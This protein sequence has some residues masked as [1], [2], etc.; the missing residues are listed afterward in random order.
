MFVEEVE[1]AVRGS[2]RGH[3]M[4]KSFSVSHLE[5]PVSSFQTPVLDGGST[6]E[7]IL[8]IYGGRTADGHVSGGDAKTQA[9]R[10]YSAGITNKTFESVCRPNMLLQ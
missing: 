5:Q 9:L 2:H 10:T 6:G 8:H 3:V 1:E 4:L 7:D